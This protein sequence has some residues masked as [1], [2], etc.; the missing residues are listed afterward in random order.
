MVTRMLLLLTHL[1]TYL[2]ALELELEQRTSRAQQLGHDA[3]GYGRSDHKLIP[4]RYVSK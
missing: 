4:Y 1:L 3:F 2:D